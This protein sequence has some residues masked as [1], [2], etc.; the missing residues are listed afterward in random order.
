VC[1]KSESD[2]SPILSDNVAIPLATLRMWVA[3]RLAAKAGLHQIDI[4]KKGDLVLQRKL[5][6][7]KL[8]AVS[9]DWAPG[10]AR[11]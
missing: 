8:G 1:S 11:F 4:N 6:K 3:F 2:K 7:L 9:V 5:E 10:L